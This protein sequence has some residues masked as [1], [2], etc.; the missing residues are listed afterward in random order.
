[1]YG[2]RRADIAGD[3]MIVDP[4]DDGGAGFDGGDFFDT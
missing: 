4:L 1:V 2:D 3:D